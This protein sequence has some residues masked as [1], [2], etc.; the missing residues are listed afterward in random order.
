[1][2]RRIKIFTLGILLT[3]FAPAQDSISILQNR[4]LQ[5]SNVQ[6][7]KEVLLET[8]SLL[9]TQEEELNI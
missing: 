2:K 6:D 4:A 5:S 1:M 8:L 3:S 9:R 7:L